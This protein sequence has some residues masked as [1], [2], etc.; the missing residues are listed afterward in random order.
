MNWMR[1]VQGPSLA[2]EVGP[3]PKPLTPD[4]KVRLGIADWLGRGK[5][6]FRD[7]VEPIRIPPHFETSLNELVNDTDEL[8]RHAGDD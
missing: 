7:G 2:V 8:D 6:V 3:N 4:E 1:L 5:R